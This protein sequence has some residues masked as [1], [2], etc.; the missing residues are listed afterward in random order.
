M[1]L[2]FCEAIMVENLKR[3]RQG[4]KKRG[5]QQER[6]NFLERYMREEIF[7]IG[8]DWT[9]ILIIG[10]GQTMMGLGSFR[11]HFTGF[12]CLEKDW[13]VMEICQIGIDCKDLNKI[14]F[15]QKGKVRIRKRWIEKVQIEKDSIGKIWIENNSIGEDWND[16]D[17]IKSFEL[18]CKDWI[19]RIGLDQKGL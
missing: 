5:R 13:I 7:H 8:R 4:E 18:Y 16:R 17:K 11:L 14:R 1:K 10:F 9:G 19:E 12:D 6:K 3:E 2:H 15:N